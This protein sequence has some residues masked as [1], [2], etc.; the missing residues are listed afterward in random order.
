MS[1]TGVAKAVDRRPPGAAAPSLPLLA[2]AVAVGFDRRPLH[3]LRPPLV[4]G[5][6][7]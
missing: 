4:A 7:T 3:F 5:I 1:T 6:V 2:A